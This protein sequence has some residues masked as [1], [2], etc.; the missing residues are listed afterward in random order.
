MQL[1]Q[2]KVLSYY[3]FIS[4]TSAGRPT[5]VNSSCVTSEQIDWCT[6]VARR[7][8]PI[9]TDCTFDPNNFACPAESVFTTN[10]LMI[11]AP[12]L[13]S[14]H[15]LLYWLSQDVML[16]FEKLL[17][18]FSFPTEESI[19]R[20]ILNNGFICAQLGHSPRL[21]IVATNYV[22][23]GYLGRFVLQLD[24]HFLRRK[25]GWTRK[26]VLEYQ[27]HQKIKS[28]VLTDQQ[29]EEAYKSASPQ[30]SPASLHAQRSKG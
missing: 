15:H 21:L 26:M 2:T 25:L 19:K 1:N 24:G 6:L 8:I 27:M 30:S 22:M 10:T 18:L 14:P 9:P 17:K 12:D 16:Q 5:D 20:I 3:V 7:S 29:I 23:R 4:M 11:P 13:S 28:I